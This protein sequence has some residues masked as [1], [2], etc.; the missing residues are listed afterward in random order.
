MRGYGLVQ[1]LQTL[2]D[3]F[4]LGLRTFRS[5]HT[6][7]HGRNLG[8][9]EGSVNLLYIV[10]TLF[11]RKPLLG[12]APTIDTV[13]HIL[14]ATLSQQCYSRLECDKFSHTAH[15]DTVAIREAHLRGTAHHYN[16]AGIQPVQYAYD[17]LS[18]GRSSDYGVIN[19]HQIILSGPD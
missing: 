12:L 16:L 9:G 15:V 18:E 8:I 11:F 14:H 17:A 1:I 10:H 19:H 2:I 4:N 3:N 7:Y 5:Q 6:G 13:C